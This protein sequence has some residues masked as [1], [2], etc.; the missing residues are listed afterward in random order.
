MERIEGHVDWLAVHAGYARAMKPRE[1][2][3]FR[4]DTGRNARDHQGLPMQI[5]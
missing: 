1:A 5:H 4:A 3:S 2:R